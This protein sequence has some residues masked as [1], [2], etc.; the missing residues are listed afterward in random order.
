MLSIELI[1]PQKTVEIN[2]NKESNKQIQNLS[3]KRPSYFNTMSKV[4]LAFSYLNIN[5]TKYL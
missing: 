4:L 5:K 1:T 3:T 2:I